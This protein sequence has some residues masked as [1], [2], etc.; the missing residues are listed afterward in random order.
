MKINFI[1]LLFNPLNYILSRFLYRADLT[2][3]PSMIKTKVLQFISYWPV[4]EL[5][6]GASKVPLSNFFM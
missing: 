3:T 4:Q 1:I 2:E 6:Q 5:K